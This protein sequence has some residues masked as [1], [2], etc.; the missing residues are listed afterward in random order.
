MLKARKSRPF[1]QLFLHYNQSWLLRRHFHFVGIRGKLD[2]GDGGGVL[3]V[4][5]HSS[6]WDGLLAYQAFRTRASGDHYVMMAERQ[7][8]QFKFFCRLG[9]YS[10]DKST[11]QAMIASLRYTVRLLQEGKRVWIWNGVRLV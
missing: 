9:A 5:N 8:R 10:I 1:D 2:A 3:Y 11:P 6:W 4:M 7:L